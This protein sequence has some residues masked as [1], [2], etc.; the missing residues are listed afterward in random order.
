MYAFIVILLVIDCLI[1]CAAV[2]LQAPKGGGLSATFGGSGSSSD[3]FMGTRQMGNLLTKMTWWC[4]GI[5]IVLAYLLQL[6]GQASGA[7]RSVLDQPFGQQQSAPAPTTSS[8]AVP[9]Q[10]A[11]PAPQ[12]ATPA[13][14][15]QPKP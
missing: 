15:T 4:G 2:L 12:S 1:L 7:P 3:A 10:P 5:F 8:P 6:M 13:P 9:L 11:N 14:S